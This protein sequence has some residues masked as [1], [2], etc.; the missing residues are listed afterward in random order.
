MRRGS[1]RGF[2]SISA[3]SL[4]LDL[5]DFVIHVSGSRRWANLPGRPMID[6]ATGAALRDDKGKIRYASPIRWINHAD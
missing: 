2:A 4:G 5:D 6:A 3:P 1:L